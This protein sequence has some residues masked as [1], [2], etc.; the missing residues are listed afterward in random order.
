MRILASIIAPSDELFVGISGKSAVFMKEDLFFSSMMFGGKF[1]GGSRILERLTPAYQATT[2]AGSLSNLTQNVSALFQGS[3]IPCV[4]LRIGVDNITMQAETTSGH[5][6][7]AIW[8]A[9]TIPTP[10]DGFYF[11]QR[12]L[13]DCLR[14]T[15]GTLRVLIDERGFLILETGQSRYFV[16]PRRPVKIAE[17]EVEKAEKKPR[18]KKSSQTK[19]A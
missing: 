8:A 4:N 1:L 19:A 14:H 12:F 3:D 7:S 10:E 2:D 9:D 11:D 5:S 15:S 18:A 16:C 13:L 17:K 6:S